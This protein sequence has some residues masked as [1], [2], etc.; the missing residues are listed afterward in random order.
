MAPSGYVSSRPDIATVEAAT[1]RIAAVAVGQAT[2]TATAANGRSAT[3]EVTVSTPKAVAPALGLGPTKVTIAVRQTVTLQPYGGQAPYAW[4]V[5]DAAVATVSAGT[6]TGVAVGS[7]VV[8][9]TDALGAHATSIVTVLA[10]RVVTVASPVTGGCGVGA[11]AAPGSAW[12][13]LGLI[14]ALLWRRRSAAR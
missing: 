6:A 14:V 1:G 5:D 12:V 10:E 11:G 3:A 7:A 9:V 8:T 2:L 4:T 13:L